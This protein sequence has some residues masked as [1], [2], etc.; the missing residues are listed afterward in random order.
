M[1]PIWFILVALVT[2]VMAAVVGFGSS[3]ILTPIAALVFDVKTA[4][5]LV[6]IFHTAGA[7]VRFLRFRPSID[8]AFLWQF[9]PSVV[10]ATLLGALFTR[11][12]PSQVLVVILGLFLVG[13]VI[14]EWTH[15]RFSLPKR[16]SLEVASG[17][18]TGFLS[19]L[20]G[21]GGALR[22][23]SLQAFGMK[24][25]EYSGSSAVIAVA[26]DLTRIPVYIASGYLFGVP[27]PWILG[28]IALGVLGTLIG[29]TIIDRVPQQTFR[30]IVLL[31]VLLVAI[32]LILD[33]I[34][35]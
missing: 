34:T 1:I 3:T 23:A 28:L 4:L 6:G 17:G 9:G 5:A 21:A 19:G 25:E 11:A 18:L 2:E 8:R 10:I 32:K 27:L 31:A 15:P 35:G 12:V 30:L 26:S 20:L 16:R 7:I 33:G 14:F 22:A 13:L 24:K 29:L